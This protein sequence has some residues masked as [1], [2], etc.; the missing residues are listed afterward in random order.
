MPK[1]L[2]NTNNGQIN[3]HTKLCMHFFIF[4]FKKFLPLVLFK[5]TYSIHLVIQFL[6]VLCYQWR[7]QSIC[8]CSNPKYIKYFI[9]FRGLA[10]RCDWKPENW[11][12]FN[13]N[14]QQMLCIFL[15]SS[16]SVDWVNRKIIRHYYLNWLHPKITP[17]WI[18][19]NSKRSLH[20]SGLHYWPK[21][22]RLREIL[23]RSFCTSNVGVFKALPD[24]HSSGTLK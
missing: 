18:L 11:N 1:L 3:K 16:F 17:L 19:F 22:L 2:L 24:W 15:N 7:H 20:Q 21:N 4:I 13:L 8:L 10:V 5:R 12:E 23:S 6:I 9:K 14:P